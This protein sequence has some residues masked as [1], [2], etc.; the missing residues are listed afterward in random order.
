MS[1]GGKINGGTG[2]ILKLYADCFVVT[3]SHVLEKYEER[4]EKGEAPNWQVGKLPPFNPLTRIAGRDT[5][6]D[7]VVLS[8]PPE[9]ERGVGPCLRSSPAIWPP[10]VPQIGQFVLV[11][12]FPG[13]L[14]EV[15]PAGWIG[16]GR[17][18]ALFRVTNVG[19]G[20]CKCRIEPGDLVSFCERPVPPPGTDIG[21][22]SGGPVFL[23]GPGYPLVGVITEHCYMESTGLELL[24]FATFDSVHIESPR[25][26]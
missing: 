1:V 10:V 19:T 14:R 3:A 7:V 21:G 26:R 17:Y 6:R 8:L 13:G 18:S 4:L 25:K 22:V 15:D 2:F 16:A 9:E 12:G 5:K 11:A 24:E 20:Y 23:V